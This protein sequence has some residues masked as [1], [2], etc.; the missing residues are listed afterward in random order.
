MAKKEQTTPPEIIE[1]EPKIEK[2]PAEEKPKYRSHLHEDYWFD[3]G[4]RLIDDSEVNINNSAEKFEKL[5]LWF[6]GVYTSIV[7]L[8]AGGFTV[9]LG[10][11]ISI[12]TLI[13]LII[14][15]VI[16]LIA[17]WLTTA[18]S[19]S[20]IVSFEH[21]SPDSI[22]EAFMDGLKEKGRYYNLARIFAFLAC[23]FIPLTIFL[24][25]RVQSGDFEV[26]R[27]NSAG[28]NYDISLSGIVPKGSKYELSIFS[29]KK[30]I[31]RKGE[32]DTGHFAEDITIPTGNKSVKARLWWTE[33]EGKG[34]SREKT[35][36]LEEK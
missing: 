23:L 1:A 13:G 31:S 11:S 15:S 29:E 22:R 14:P 18:A 36:E 34:A 5:I 26:L 35:V 24:A 25:N 19:T 16:L 17:Y 6:W 30:T 32:T 21:R 20:A 28:D 3:V 7:G 8:G 27:I 12:G 9:F 10:K 4:K 2:A 33:S